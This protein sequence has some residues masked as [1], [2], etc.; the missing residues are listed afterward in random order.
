MQ[1]HNKNYKGIFCPC[2]IEV[3]TGSKTGKCKSCSCK[4]KLKKPAQYN[5][6][7]YCKCEYRIYPC[8]LGKSSF[9]SRVCQSSDKIGKKLPE[10]R[11][12]RSIEG[13]SG[14]K[15]HFWKGGIT[16][17]NKAIRGSY[18]YKLWRESVFKRDN[19]TCLFCFKRSGKGE[20]VTLQADHI[21]PFA[22]F[23]ELRLD[24]SNGRTLCVEC[25]KQTD[26]YLNKAK[27]YAVT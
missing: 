7:A 12:R 15:S 5:I 25:H 4:G 27:K 1:L 14:A 9:C 22:Y 19:W 2:G 13:H 6:C 21:K 10:E 16:S 23:P 11:V 26:T 24:V 20:K 3:S 17:I 18:D 8:R